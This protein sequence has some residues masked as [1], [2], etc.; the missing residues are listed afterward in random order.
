MND[1]PADCQ[2]REWTDPQRDRCHGF[3]VTDE[4]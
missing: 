2:N 4:V 1:S 3:A